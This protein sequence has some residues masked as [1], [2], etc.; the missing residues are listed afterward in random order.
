MVDVAQLVR[1]PDCG[2]GGRGFKSP[3]SPFFCAAC[4]EAAFFLPEL[5]RWLEHSAVRRKGR[6]VLPKAFPWKN[7]LIHLFFVRLV[8]K[9]H[10]FYQSYTVG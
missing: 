7:P 10:F 9:P 4:E 1:A 2:S 8:K 6:G 3:H 5:Y